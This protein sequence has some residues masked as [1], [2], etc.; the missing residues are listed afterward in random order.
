[1]AQRGRHAHRQ[2]RPQRRPP[3]ALHAAA[4]RRDR[5]GVGPGLRHSHARRPDAGR[6]ART[7]RLAQDDPRPG[8]LPGHGDRDGVGGRGR[9]DGAADRSQALRGG[10]HRRPRG[11]C[12][13]GRGDPRLRQGGTAGGSGGVPQLLGPRHRE[14]RRRGLAGPGVRHRHR[15]GPGRHRLRARG[16][17]RRPVGPRG[18]PHGGARAAGAGHG[19]HVR[20]HR[21]AGGGAR[22][23][24]AHGL[25][26][27]ARDRLRRR[28]LYAP[29]GRWHAARHL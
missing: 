3:P 2:R 19:A 4:V 9:R 29:G 5:A 16:E 23:H 10:A 15:R 26:V 24:Q 6:H 1:M 28:D 17:L 12:R 18:G 20:G 7:A 27:E 8:S 21:A 11:P 25:G 13:P 22:L 14:R